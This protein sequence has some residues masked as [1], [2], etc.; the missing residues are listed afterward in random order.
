MSGLWVVCAFAEDGPA[1]ERLAHALALPC[2]IVK[3]HRFPDGESRIRID[4]VPELAIIYRSL[5]QPND[6]LVELLLLSSVL[7][8][9]TGGR[10]VL[11]APYLPYMRQ[12]VAF[13]PG[14]AVSQRVI[15]RLLAAPH[16]AVIAVDP[17]LHRTPSLA[18]IFPG[19]TATAVSAAPL[20]ATLIDGKGCQ[21][22]VLVGPDSEAEPLVAAVARHAA[23]PFLIL[24]KTRHGDRDVSIAAADLDLVRG[25]RVVLVDDIVSTGG[26]LIEAA[27]R[28]RSAG[29]AAIEA[30]AVHDLFDDVAIA[31]MAGAG[32]ARVRSTDSLPHATNAAQLAPLL[33]TAVRAA[34]TS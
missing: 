30:L 21:P 1:A 17:H 12:D 31:A 7:S 19:T 9:S 29:C 26:T 6:K 34:L 23:L 5:H 28:L 25:R 3:C 18:G 22:P 15:G 24:D 10:A 14:E 33:A 8:D 13:H 27:Q 11:V 4:P 32:I 2:Q 16:R 20:L